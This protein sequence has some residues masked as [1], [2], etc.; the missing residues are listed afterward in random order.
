MNGY[1]GTPP[2]DIVRSMVQ[3]LVSI[4]FISVAEYSLDTKLLHFLSAEKKIKNIEIKI[5][6]KL[7]GLM[8]EGNRHGGLQLKVL[9]TQS[10]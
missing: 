6:I 3:E 4:A 9:Q 10:Q 2:A 8:T 7:L 1:I 5:E